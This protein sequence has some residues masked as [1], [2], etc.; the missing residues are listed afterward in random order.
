MNLNIHLI[1]GLHLFLKKRLKEN[2]NSSNLFWT[3]ILI[4]G[5]EPKS[6]HTQELSTIPLQINEN[7]T[8]DGD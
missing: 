8:L 7:F 2:K 3:N 1:C 5:G 6:L 4:G